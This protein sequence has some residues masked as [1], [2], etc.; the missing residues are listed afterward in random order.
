[1]SDPIYQNQTPPQAVPVN[2]GQGGITYIAQP[3]GQWYTITYPISSIIFPIG[4]GG[5][6]P[7]E[8]PE[9]KK[10][11]KRDPDGCACKKCKEFYQFAEPNQE[12]GTLICYSCRTYG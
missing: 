10:K 8:A 6:S 7:P 2:N 5:N 1:M 4:G 9:E 3:N 12:D 11:S